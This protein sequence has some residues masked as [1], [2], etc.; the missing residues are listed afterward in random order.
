M[1]LHAFI[2]GCNVIAIRKNNLN[3]GMTCA[4]ASMVGYEK[5]SM[6]IGSQSDTGKVLAIGD[7][8]GISSLAKDQKDIAYF[9]G[10]NHSTEMDKFKD[11]SYNLNDTAITINGA[12]VM[13][14]A[15]V[16]EILHLKDIEEDNL[17]ILDIIKYND[18]SEKE[19]L[20]FE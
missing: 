9:I 2:C 7:V 16:K 11:I 18:N 1:G 15:K 3:Y 20:V 14:I 17:V 13:M 8:V 4:W 19:F 5:V 12:K 6:L 10:D